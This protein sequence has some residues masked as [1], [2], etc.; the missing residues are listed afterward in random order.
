MG[1][2]PRRFIKFWFLC[3]FTGF[4]AFVLA[5]D[6]FT[7]AMGGAAQRLEWPR[8]FTGQPDF[9]FTREE[10]LQEAKI[11]A[12]RENARE[13]VLPGLEGLLKDDTKYDPMG[14]KIS[15]NVGEVSSTVEVSGSAVR[16]QSLMEKLMLNVVALPAFDESSSLDLAEFEDMMRKTVSESLVAWQPEI[17]NFPLDGVLGSLVLQA[18]V[19]SPQKYV[20]LNG[21][22]Y[23]EGDSFKVQIPVQV[24]DTWILNALEEKIPEE[25]VVGGE[26]IGKY[27]EVFENVIAEF[28]Q[29]RNQNPIIGQKMLVLPVRLT[30]I[31]PRKVLLEAE[32]RQ[33]E[34][35]VRFSY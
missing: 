30:Q 3:C 17:K 31:L 23:R 35:Q 34:L 2:M 13:P 27:R 18:V 1:T 10:V 5:C 9:A 25:N 16:G 6:G 8:T 20:I 11:R 4:F 12:K 32:G 22:R 15:E 21:D 28:A 29:G 26:V 24:P 33:Y 7:Q 14:M 19:L